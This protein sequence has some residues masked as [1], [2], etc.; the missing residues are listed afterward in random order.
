[1]V[2]N[3]QR[4]DEPATEQKRKTNNI[5][6]IPS[7][8]IQRVSTKWDQNP[9]RLPSHPGTNLQEE[10]KVTCHKYPR[11]SQDRS[12]EQEYDE[13]E[14]FRTF[15]SVAFA[16]FLE[17]EKSWTARSSAPW[18]GAD[19]RLQS[20]P[21]SLQVEYSSF[22]KTPDLNLSALS[23]QRAEAPRASKKDADGGNSYLNEQVVVARVE[24]ELV[25]PR[26][27]RS[28]ETRRLKA[29][30]TEQEEGKH[31]AFRRKSQASHDSISSFHTARQG[32]SV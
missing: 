7:L 21:E 4:Q 5:K 10:S 8:G 27:S 11:N 12:T 29:M 32:D 17:T 3:Q 14:D 18:H 31:Q 13:Q 25:H 20:Y 30:V 9:F 1:M 15:A 19:D 28:M 16:G 6:Q 22:F 23:V 2:G 26:P 24:C